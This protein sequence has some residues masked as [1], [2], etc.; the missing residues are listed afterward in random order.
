MVEK[1][2]RWEQCMLLQ[3]SRELLVPI[4]ADQEGEKRA[5]AKPG[6]KVNRYAEPQ[7]PIFFY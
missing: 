6:C 2:W 5:E 1:A 7:G 4:L 3:K